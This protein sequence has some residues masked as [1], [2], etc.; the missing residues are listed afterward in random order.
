MLQLDKIDEPLL[1]KLRRRAGN[2]MLSIPVVFT[3]IFLGF[4]VLFDKPVLTGII[5]SAIVWGIVGF[6]YFFSG[7]KKTMTADVRNGMQI[8]RRGRIKAVHRTN[9]Y[10]MRLKTV[11]I[12]LEPAASPAG[13][14]AHDSFVIFNSLGMLY[15]DQFKKDQRYDTFTGKTAEIRY[16][17]KSGVVLDYT[18]L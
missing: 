17:P 10:R 11:C 1:I 4:T 18:I 5:C 7:G 15:Y 12:E 16:F 14:P 13:Y 2:R 3:V 8:I 9:S 6:D